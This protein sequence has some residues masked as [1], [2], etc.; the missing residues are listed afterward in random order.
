MS[1]ILKGFNTNLG[2]NEY[3]DTDCFNNI[4][5]VQSVIFFDFSVIRKDLKYVN[6]DYKQGLTIKNTPSISPSNYIK[7]TPFSGKINY[8]VNHSITNNGVHIFDHSISINVAKRQ[9]LIDQELN[10]N[11]NAIWS[12]SGKGRKLL[13]IVIDNN[14][15][16]YALGWWS[17]LRMNNGG[18]GSGT[19]KNG[20]TTYNYS[21]NAPQPWFEIQITDEFKNYFNI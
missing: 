11:H 14:G 3:K 16:Y 8:D 10:T 20:G 9:H 7:Y 18:G 21:F 12:L 4:G 15:N 2:N 6:N 5:G 1:N 17:G 13:A 19:N